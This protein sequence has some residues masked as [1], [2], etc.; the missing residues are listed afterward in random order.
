MRWCEGHDKK[1]ETLATKDDI[2]ALKG[3][4]SDLKTTLQAILDR[5]PPK[6]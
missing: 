2:S 5:L 1:V 4:I 3:D 6:Q